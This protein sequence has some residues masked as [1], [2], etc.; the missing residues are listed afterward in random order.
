MYV[1]A[2]GGPEH[3]LVEWARQG[4]EK[5][6]YLVRHS[7]NGDAHEVGWIHSTLANLAHEVGLHAEARA[8]N[9]NEIVDFLTQGYLVVASV[10]Y[11]VGDDR[12]PI[13]KKGGHLLVVVGA[14]YDKGGPLAFYVNNPSGRRTELQAEARLT[15]ERF[16]LAYSGRVILFRCTNT[17]AETG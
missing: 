2:L 13:T 16:T 17:L 9:L 3:S 14:E 6:G 4:V 8:A 11:E 7:E 1:E 15:V 10:S 5:G 12:L